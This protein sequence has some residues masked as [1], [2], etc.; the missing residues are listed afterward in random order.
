MKIQFDG[1]TYEYNTNDECV[2]DAW[3][4]Y[5]GAVFKSA[6]GEYWIYDDG[7]NAGGMVHE[8]EDE[9]LKAAIIL[10]IILDGG[11]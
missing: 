7:E 9:A 3:G 1:H 4:L 8:N 5:M 10:L 6:C 11:H 2:Y